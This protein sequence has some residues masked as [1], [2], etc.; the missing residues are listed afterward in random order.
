M[1]HVVPRSAF[2][3]LNSSLSSEPGPGLSEV[4]FHQFSGGRVSKLVPLSMPESLPIR[5]LLSVQRRNFEEG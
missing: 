4:V 3:Q 2:A 5:V 1:T